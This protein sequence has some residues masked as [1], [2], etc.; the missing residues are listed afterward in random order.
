[1]IPESLLIEQRIRPLLVNTEWFRNPLVLL[2]RM[3]SKLVVLLVSPHFRRVRT[4]ELLLLMKRSK[5]DDYLYYLKSCISI[6]IFLINFLKLRKYFSFFHLRNI[7]YNCKQR[8]RR[9]NKHF[10]VHLWRIRTAH[11]LSKE[12]KGASY[13][14]R[15]GWKGCLFPARVGTL[16]FDAILFDSTFPYLYFDL[17]C[18]Q[19]CFPP[20]KV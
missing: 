13:E 20:G 7:L 14:G 8:C 5:G 11:F 3:G 1:M 6:F 19:F 16:S 18:K 17:A 10:D 4:N 9:G 15:D 2:V 12:G